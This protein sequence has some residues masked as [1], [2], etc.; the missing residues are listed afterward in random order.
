MGFRHCRKSSTDATTGCILEWDSAFK[1]IIIRHQYVMK[2]V[3]MSIIGISLFVAG[4]QH[5]RRQVEY[6]TAQSA[7]TNKT[8]YVE[9]SASQSAN[10][11]N[12]VAF[13]LI[14]PS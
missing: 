13:R 14:K 5:T 8:N 6:T 9:A 10:L 11:R 7:L 1:L 3:V 12:S 2:K 4:Y